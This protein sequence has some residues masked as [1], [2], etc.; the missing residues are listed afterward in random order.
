MEDT[1]AFNVETTWGTPEHLNS[2]TYVGYY[3]LTAKRDDARTKNILVLIYRN[4]VTISLPAEGVNKSMSYYFTLRFENVYC[5][6]DG[7]LRFSA[8][9]QP[10]EIVEANIPRH[11]FY[12]NG[13]AS[14]EAVKNAQVRPQ[15]GNFNCQENWAR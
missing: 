15:I 13:Y 8:P 10:V 6:A 11:N 3:L 2:S 5:N 12:Y 7:S 4:D 9:Q 1:I 14:L